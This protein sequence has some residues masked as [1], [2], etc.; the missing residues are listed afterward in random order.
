ML[1][2]DG[3]SESQSEKNVK[4]VFIIVNAS[5]RGKNIQRCTDGMNS[6]Q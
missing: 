6:N 1:I 2:I 5:D 4:N 3:M